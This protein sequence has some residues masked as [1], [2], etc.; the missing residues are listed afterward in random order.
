MMLLYCHITFIKKKKN[1]IPI[2]FST[3]SP[4][5]DLGLAA[6]SKVELFVIIVNG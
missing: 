3:S 4:E 6:T 2:S 5:A 1:A